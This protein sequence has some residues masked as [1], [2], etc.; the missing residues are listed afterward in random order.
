MQWRRD[1]KELFIVT[2]FQGIFLRS[3]ARVENNNFYFLSKSGKEKKSWGGVL[4]FKA[5]K[6]KVMKINE[7]FLK[8][9]AHY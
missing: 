6:S 7:C 5:D 1:R 4:W 9:S 3:L 2:T 8:Q